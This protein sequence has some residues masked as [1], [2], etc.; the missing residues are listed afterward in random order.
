V[1]SDAV[2]STSSR[3]GFLARAG[4]LLLAASG[5]GV[6]AAAMKA[7]RAEAFHFCG[8]IY[9]T[10]S[11]PHPVGLPRIDSH[12]FPL[13]ASDGHPVDDL[14]RPVDSQ[15]RPVDSHGNLL[16]DPD[17]N[18]LPSASRTRVCAVAAKDFGFKPYLDGSWYRC[19]GGHVRRLVDCCGYVSRRINGDAALTGYCYHGRHVFCVMY[20]DSKVKC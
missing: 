7:D 2:V 16:R 4:K 14:G 1:L 11:C 3:R 10:G 5:T 8:H 6:I 9:T 19:C 12:G 20:Y 17:G 13:R 15:D 18:P